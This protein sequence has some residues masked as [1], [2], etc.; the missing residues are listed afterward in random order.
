MRVLG[1]ALTQQDWCPDKKKDTRGA[2]T[3]ERL[4]E[5][6]ARKGG[7]LQW[8]RQTSEEPNS[9]ATLTLDSQPAEPSEN[10]LLLF[11]PKKE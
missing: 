5:K 1:W 11:K 2:C 8:R 6:E 4:Y 7:Y 10:S 3:E 9:P